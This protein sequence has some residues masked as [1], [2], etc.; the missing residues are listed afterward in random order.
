LLAVLF[1]P[2]VGAILLVAGAQRARS[3]DTWDAYA[4][5]A[6]V[7]FTVPLAYTLFLARRGQ[8]FLRSAKA[9][10]ANRAAIS[11]ARPVGF[12]LAALAVATIGVGAG[13]VATVVY[14]G[15]GGASLGISPGIAANFLRLWREKWSKS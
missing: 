3:T 8:L 10:A 11:R 14:A 7:A 4:A 12:V 1:A 15:L 5:V 13:S 6:L 9:I 2:F